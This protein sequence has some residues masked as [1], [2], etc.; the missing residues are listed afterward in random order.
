MKNRVPWWW[1]APLASLLCSAP[2]LAQKPPEARAEASDKAPPRD[3]P[4]AF[5][6]PG[7]TAH[8]VRRIEGPGPGGATTVTVMGPA[9]PG[10]PVD[11]LTLG[12]PGSGGVP[13]RLLE[14]L[15]VPRET[16]KEVEDLTFEANEAVIPLEADLKR[17]QLR[18]ERQL[19]AE[20]PDEP[21]VLKLVEEIGRAET[22]VRRNR[23]GLMLR[24][25]KALG[26]EVWRKVEGMA[27]PVT[28]KIQIHG[29]GG[30]EMEDIRG[31]EESGPGRVIRRP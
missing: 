2:A 25:R 8:T 12:G 26:P 1:S 17:A 27:P 11:V 31:P 16:V 19:D 14:R 3:E 4:P 15:G 9:S 6:G 24:I 28:K 20:K 7:F 30:L 22:A 29:P 5:A 23:V 13:S 21:A 18:F 10:L